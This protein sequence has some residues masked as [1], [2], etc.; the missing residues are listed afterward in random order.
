M[1]IAFSPAGKMEQFFLDV[2]DRKAPVKEPEF[3]RRYD[4]ELVGPS[5]F[6]KS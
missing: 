1:L 4:T 3:W 2:E 6:W 5:P